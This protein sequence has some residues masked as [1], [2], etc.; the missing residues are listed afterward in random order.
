VN[1]DFLAIIEAAY[2]LDLDERRWLEAIAEAAQGCLDAGLGIIAYTFDASDPARLQTHALAA[3]GPARDIDW[4]AVASRAPEIG[5]ERMRQ[6]YS[7]APPALLL[8]ECLGSPALDPATALPPLRRDLLENGIVDCIGI[9]GIDPSAKGCLLCVPLP[10]PR[11]LAPKTRRL[12][13]QVAAH[14][15]AGWRLR[16]GEH[17]QDDLETTDALLDPRGRLHRITGR[18]APVEDLQALR[19]AAQSITLSK[20]LRMSDPRRSVEL[21][22]ALVAGRWSLVEQFQRDGRHYLLVKRNDPRVNDPR[23]L[24]LRERQVVAY[25]RLGHSNKLIAYELGLAPS[26]VSQQ[27]QSALGKLGIRSRMALV[28]MFGARVAD[29]PSDEESDV[30]AG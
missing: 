17:A 8:S 12:L 29:E 16:H 10:E 11:R 23:A 27:L 9:R 25:A 22:K 6:L 26:T 4:A 13:S 18:A 1:A 21:W 24:T 5:K 28:R 7:P 3:V 2:R 19:A 30:S 14:L 15:A 20:R